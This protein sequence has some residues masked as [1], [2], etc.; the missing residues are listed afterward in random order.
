M[1]DMIDV[2]SVVSHP[3]TG[4]LQLLAGPGQRQV[5]RVHA[6]ILPGYTRSLSGVVDQLRANR[7]E[8]HQALVIVMASHIVWDWHI[9]VLLR[10]LHEQGATALVLP[11]G[12]VPARSSAAD[13]AERL[14][15]ALVTTSD[16][17][18]VYTVTEAVLSGLRSRADLRVLDLVRI[19]A[20]T[21]LGLGQT[22]DR[23]ASFFSRPVVLFDATGH[24][25]YGPDDTPPS[26]TSATAGRYAG[27]SVLVRNHDLDMGAVAAG[28]TSLS[29][30][31]DFR[32]SSGRAL[33]ASPVPA[34]DLG[35][36][37]FGAEVDPAIGPDRAYYSPLVEA[38]ALVCGNCVAR[39][40][41]HEQR[42]SMRERALIE[43][44]K[45]TDPVRVRP[46]LLQ[47][48]AEEG[49]NLAADH[50]V[51]KAN[52]QTR[53]RAAETVPSLTQA[54]RSEMDRSGI[55]YNLVEQD[56][57]WLLWFNT[58][59]KR[60][61]ASQD[62]VGADRPPATTLLRKAAK[63][64]RRSIPVCLGISTVR[65]GADGFVISLHEAEDTA[66][67]AATRP[68]SGY[69]MAAD[70]LSTEQL[71]LA[72]TS[73]DS[74]THTVDELLEPLD[75]AASTLRP[76]LRAYL[77][78]ESSLSE[79]AALLG[80]HRNTVRDRIHRIEAILGVDLHQPDARLALHLAVRAAG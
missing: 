36:L 15:V 78:A 29:G 45:V 72:W 28:A 73:A 5:A 39:T 31:Q 32:L 24:V 60:P 43:E 69:V 77:D 26:E 74:F 51:V 20:D 42:G 54:V 61:M 68:Q 62:S 23:I 67:V 65:S 21:S 50:C 37:W 66:K 44:F 9:D 49:W 27:G 80:V 6:V 2:N 58:V 16:P 18:P 35:S 59:G 10:F 14:Q 56:T 3:E 22:Y 38:A 64:I 7:A 40:R 63:V 79:T 76:T 1:V 25:L 48:A 13:L 75:R 8:L 17:R 46:D 11:K 4:E 47:K 33:M 19:G 55:H 53:E 52:L 70:N 12:S 34:D 41:M 71:L 57:G 30:T